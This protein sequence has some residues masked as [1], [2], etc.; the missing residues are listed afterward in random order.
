MGEKIIT[1]ERCFNLREGRKAGEL[2]VLPP[3]MFEPSKT[4]QHNAR[5]LTPEILNAM[6]QEYY[7]LRNWDAATGQPT[8]DT[9]K[10]LGLGEVSQ[11]LGD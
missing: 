2:D 7:Q 5:T 1:L 9:L 11:T 4:I 6:L 3:R 8:A 10:M